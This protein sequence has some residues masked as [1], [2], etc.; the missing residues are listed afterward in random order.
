MPVRGPF[1]FDHVSFGVDSADDLWAL[2][3][4]LV[5]ASLEVS[6]VIDHGFIHSIY[7]FNP[8]GIPIEFSYNVPGLDVRKEPFLGDQMPVATARE[9]SEPV[10][11]VWP[12][13]EQE[14]PRER[15]FTRPGAGSDLVSYQY[16]KAQ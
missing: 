10:S 9:G 5:A 1:I 11:G 2:R 4:K 3:D 13:V 12:A 8:N 14:T 15:R 7:T 6:D 16:K